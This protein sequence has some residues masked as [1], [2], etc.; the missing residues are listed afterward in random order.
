MQKTQTL[1]KTV[2]ISNN[3]GRV[4]PPFI[5]RKDKDMLLKKKNIVINIPDNNKEKIK[6]YIEE[7]GYSLY[8]EKNVYK[9]KTKKA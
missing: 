1:I 7:F 3:R 4:K 8:D 9:K 5:F 6:K 2:K